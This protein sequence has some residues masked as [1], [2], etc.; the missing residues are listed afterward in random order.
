MAKRQET[1]RSLQS[2]IDQLQRE[3]DHMR[4]NT[5]PIT[6]TQSVRAA[7]PAERYIVNS[8]SRVERNKFEI[9][10]NLFDNLLSLAYYA[11]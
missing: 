4:Y 10:I 3:I 5:V 9:L 11:T 7:T 8:R 1:E 2:R 6:A